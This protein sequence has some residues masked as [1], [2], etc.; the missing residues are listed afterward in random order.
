[1]KGSK[2][3]ILESPNITSEL[4]N[5]IKN[6]KNHIV[7]PLNYKLEDSLNNKNIKII[8]E[9]DIL[10]NL[11]YKFIDNLTLKL[12]GQWYKENNVN[13]QIVYNNIDISKSL[14][15]ELYQ[16]FL[17]MNHRII[18]TH[19]LIDEY[20]PNYVKNFTEDFTLA[21]LSKEICQIKEIKYE[22]IQKD[23]KEEIKNIFNK[24]SFSI[25]IFG[26]N[27]DVKVSKRSF[28]ILK[29]FYEKYW[30]LRYFVG[31]IKAKKKSKIGKSVLFL[32]FNLV[33]HEDFL[34]YLSKKDYNLLFMNDRRPIIWNKKALDISKKIIFNKVNSIK[35]EAKVKN[36]DLYTSFEKKINKNFLNENFRIKEYDLSDHF[37]N[38]ILEILKRRLP[39]MILK[40][41]HIEKIIKTKKIDFVWMLDDWGESRIIVNVFQ[42]H[43][44]PV[45]LFL[46]GSLAAI[47]PKD[48]IW[49][50]GFAKNRVANK[51]IL[52]GENDL[53]NCQEMGVDLTR[54]EIG[55]APRYDNFEKREKSDDDYI[56][57]LIGGFP[58]T[59]YSYFLSVSFIANFQKKITALFS[60]LQ[61]FNK[62]IIL[63]RHPTQG[64]NEI[65]DYVK[66][67]HNFIPEATILKEEDTIEL[68]SKAS[69]VISVPSTSLV[70]AILLDKP[71]IFLPYIETDS[72]I[73]YSSSNAVITIKENDNI[74][75]IIHDCL[76]DKNTRDFLDK[77]RKEFIKKVFNY[78]N[79]A[80]HKHE[81][82]MSKM[83]KEKLNL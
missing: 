61:N 28:V 32:D 76:F 9:E 50:I 44:I 57:I 35:I 56:L 79:S 19:K 8:K 17:R 82:I 75:Q 59:G 36:N 45:A 65:L 51:L 46:A 3:F 63:K 24:V 40:I 74:T 34:R 16:I 11:D 37:K 6:T 31:T 53:K 1:M 39:E 80:S 72:G 2:I 10:N 62:K 23:S 15:N 27:K 77:G 48:S 4:L 22:I 29:Y 78:K 21:N 41:E 73:P 54:L 42:N 70:E 14:Q 12:S 5:E 60:S 58:S 30:D 43:N 49:P 26:K 33:N 52:W 7:V 47:K 66:L 20:E 69:L 81:Q 67:I 83:I 64:R 55:G 38:L 18:L 68:I 71:V 13:E 25:R